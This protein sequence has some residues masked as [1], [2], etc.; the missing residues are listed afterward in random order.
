MVVASFVRTMRHMSE[1]RMF[2]REMRMFARHSCHSSDSSDSLTTLETVHLS[3]GRSCSA[4]SAPA[5]TTGLHETTAGN[6]KR[7]RRAAQLLVGKRVEDGSRPTNTAYRAADD[8]QEK[9]E[10]RFDMEIIERWLRSHTRQRRRQK[11][12]IHIGEQNGDQHIIGAASN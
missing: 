3:H 9:K 6:S 10:V 12:I 8:R 7:H 5:I 2:A 11:N 4:T 1:I